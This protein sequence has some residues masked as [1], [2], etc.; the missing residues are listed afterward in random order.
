MKPTF[1]Y[2]LILATICFSVTSCFE[3]LDLNQSE[4]FESNPVIT[5]SL[6]FFDE[7]AQTFILDPGVSNVIRDTISL[8]IFND[9]FVVDNLERAEFLFETINSINREFQSTVE[10]LN[11]DF[12][13]QHTFTIDV[14][15]S[16]N[17][18]NIVMTREEIFEN[19][20]LESLTASTQV[21][22]ILT[23]QEDLS[24]PEIDENTPGR[25]SLRSVGTF[26]LNINSSE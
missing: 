4:D 14:P 1:R 26:F 22:F 5:S 3:G 10:F 21:I 8:E 23:L 19:Q 11:D 12:E 24:L 17:N 15:R 25:F 2:I 9:P 6:A 13:L 7:S 18:E 20:T 16:P